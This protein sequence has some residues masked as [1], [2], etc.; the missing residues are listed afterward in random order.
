MLIG[1]NLTVYGKNMDNESNNNYWWNDAFSY[2]IPINVNVPQCRNVTVQITLDDKD[3]YYNDTPSNGTGLAFVYNNTVLPYVVDSWNYGG[4]SNLSVFIHSKRAGKTVIWLYYG[5]TGNEQY[6]PAYSKDTL[7][8]NITYVFNNTL[9]TNVSV[10]GEYNFEK[11]QSNIMIGD[12]INSEGGKLILTF[13]ASGFNAISFNYYSSYNIYGKIKVFTNNTIS[14]IGYFSGFRSYFS[15]FN[16]SDNVSIELYNYYPYSE[17]YIDNVSLYTY[18]NITIDSFTNS[19]V[20]NAV[21]IFGS[22]Q[23]NANGYVG[24]CLQISQVSVQPRSGSIS[25][26]FNSKNINTLQF[27][28][29]ISGYLINAERAELGVNIT[30]SDKKVLEYILFNINSTIIP[31]KN[32]KIINLTVNDT[33][34]WLDFNKNIYND[35]KGFD[36]ASIETVSFFM[37]SKSSG[38]ISFTAGIDDLEILFSTSAFATLDSNQLNHQP[39]LYI[40]YPYSGATESMQ[41]QIYGRAY[42]PVGIKAVYVLWNNFT[43]NLSL[44]RHIENNKEMVFWSFLLSNSSNLQNQTFKVEAYNNY[45]ISNEESININ[46]IQTGI[47]T[48][49]INSMKNGTVIA[50]TANT[51]ISGSS[52]N[53][54]KLVFQIDSFDYVPSNINPW[55]ITFN[56]SAANSKYQSGWYVFYIVGTDKYGTVYTYRSINYINMGPIIK[57]I[58]FS[59][60][61]ITDKSNV[62]INAKIVSD[63]QNLTVAAHF[64]INSCTLSHSVLLKSG[65]ESMV[66]SA[67]I[68]IYSLGTVIYF[69]LMVTDQISTVYS[70]LL[71]ITIANSYAVG[72]INISGQRALNSF[73]TYNFCT[74]KIYSYSGGLVVNNTPFYLNVSAGSANSIVY[75]NNGSLKFSYTTP[76]VMNKISEL[77]YIN[78]SSLQGSATGS[79]VARVNYSS[80]PASPINLT[81]LHKYQN[82]PEFKICWIDPL[83]PVNITGAFYKIGTEPVNNTDYSGYVSGMELTNLTLNISPGAHNIYIWLKNSLGKYSFTE[84]SSCT[85]IFENTAPKTGAVTVNNGA[86]YSLTR[87]LNI[88][89][90]GFS[91]KYGIERYYYTAFTAY[92][93]KFN[94]SYSTSFS[95]EVPCDGYYIIEVMAQNYALSNSTPAFAFI[96]VDTVNPSGRLVINNNA[97]YS[98]STTLSLN[99]TGIKGGSQISY[100]RISQNITFSGSSWIPYSQYYNYT[101]EAIQQNISIFVQLKAASGRVSEIFNSSI[102]LDLVAPF[103]TRVIIDFNSKYTDSNNLTLQIF[104]TDN[105]SGIIAMR[106]STDPTFTDVKWL[107]YESYYIYQA[108]NISEGFIF[109][110]VQLKDAANNTSPVFYSDIA[111]LPSPPQAAIGVRGNMINGTAYVNSTNISLVF[112]VSD[113][114][115]PIQS[116]EI[117]NYPDMNYSTGWIGYQKIYSWHLAQGAGLKTVYA[118]F[119]NEFGNSTALAYIDIYLVPQIQQFYANIPPGY[120]NSSYYNQT[121]LTISG[122]YIDPAPVTISINNHTVICD[123]NRFKYD[124]QLYDGINNVTIRIT[125]AANNSETID[126]QIIASFTA[127]AINIS[128]ISTY[129]Q[130]NEYVFY[131]YNGTVL[132]RGYINSTILLSLSIDDEIVPVMHNNSFIYLKNYPAGSYYLNFTAIDKS[133]NIAFLSKKIEVITSTPAI[134]NSTVTKFN[135]ISISTNYNLLNITWYL[136]NKPVKYGTL[137]FE[138]PQ[139]G[140]TQ[141][142]TVVISDPL[143]TTMKT[144]T[145]NAP[146]TISAWDV[147]I[148]FFSIILLS[149]L[150][151]YEHKKRIALSNKKRE[152][153]EKGISSEVLDMVMEIVS[154]HH[155]DL[156]KRILSIALD[157]GIDLITFNNVIEILES[158]K[159]IKCEKDENGEERIYRL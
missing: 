27:Q 33:D 31:D 9:P 38:F 101:V 110:Y 145:I 126:K 58:Y 118:R 119:K 29:N 45:N 88:S 70:P 34:R 107:P 106:I 140:K 89:I 96:T 137:N 49:Q 71:N 19:T 80:Y 129:I 12:K 150:Y 69:R 3:F 15:N 36:N 17:I 136:N 134:L 152:I 13:P 46:L 67:S 18:S 105:I 144:W 158:E 93:D 23:V 72:V 47:S 7:L 11:I 51:T 75:S 95:I 124:L 83:S 2:R 97:T 108:K 98:N 149:T 157:S 26:F 16:S 125:D 159:K 6:D 84:N 21:G 111:Y 109:I 153:D 143:G 74:N 112:N 1:T 147:S 5:E 14:T 128:A 41:I 63:S 113:G 44:V 120:L 40:D 132:V 22:V 123:G 53:I 73:Q 104:G 99:I 142:V 50:G 127:P 130:D 100:M 62:T 64:G 131:S 37:I 24:N 78:I 60:A 77:I 115:I 146:Y 87:Q 76:L 65:N 35:S 68:G 86:N 91:D 103:N 20:P 48:V 61:V 85:I 57:S 52:F 8:Q 102:I 79:Y 114:N 122:Y 139:S 154:R 28:Y 39:Q 82:Y 116:M 25:T 135:E 138:V 30:F 133:G 55:S 54:Q 90:S 141:I 92:S 117:S 42:D 56:F 94:V 156:K 151:I 121:N 59:P 43:Y 66:F 148:I 4:I 155:S 81:S 10:K 32:L